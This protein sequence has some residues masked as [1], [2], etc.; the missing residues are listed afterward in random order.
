ML[1]YDHKVSQIAELV[2]ITTNHFWQVNFNPAQ[3][4]NLLPQ[5]TI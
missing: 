3:V 1:G 4:F 5:E 2:W